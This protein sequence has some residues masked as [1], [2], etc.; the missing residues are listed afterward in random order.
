MSGFSPKNAGTNL[1][2]AAAS[3]ASCILYATRERATGDRAIEGSRSGA[4]LQ[5]R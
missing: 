3:A 5:H 1:I 2:A 4:H